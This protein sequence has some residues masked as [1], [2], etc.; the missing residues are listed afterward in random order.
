MA[1]DHVEV[2]GQDFERR[3]CEILA[4][5]YEAVEAGQVSDRAEWLARYPDLS[6]AAGRFLDDQD[7]L[8]ALTEP[9]RPTVEEAATSEVLSGHPAGMK[10]RSIGDYELIEEI[11]RGGMG[12]VF[13]ARQ[14]GLDRP[15]ALK[16]LRAD[17]LTNEADQERFLR[18]AKAAANLDHPNIVP[19]FEVGQHEGQNYFTMKLVGGTSLARRLPDYAS[20]QRAAARLVATVAL[21]VAHAHERGILH[22]DLKP[23]NILVDAH[24]QPHVSD[25]GLA[26]WVNEASDL[27]LSGAILGTPGYMAPEQATGKKGAVTTATDVYGLGAVLYTLLTGR[28]PFQADSVL[29][30]IEDVKGR[31]PDPPS[32]VNGCVDRDLETICLKCLEKE[33]ARRYRSA[34]DVADELERWLQGEPIVARPL[35][36]PARWRRWAWRR[37]LLLVAGAA[38]LVMLVLVGLGTQQA[39]RLRQAGELAQKQDRLIRGRADEARQAKYVSD[40]GRASVLI[41]QSEARE[42]RDV[43]DRYGTA[44]VAED[45]RGF[46]WY[47]LRGLTDVARKLGWARRRA[48]VPRRV[49]PRRP[50]VRHGGP[51]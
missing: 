26:R 49:C 43:L 18:E 12:V 41:A 21:A 34:Q 25:F 36:R 3:L 4:A 13:R 16:M 14:R 32:T 28:P 50:H 5:Y 15:V 33:P 31:E 19:I 23:S 27:T 10:G 6:D 20:D 11:A 29:E 24:G 39:I 1:S 7:R 45:L 9:L 47:Y 44:T 35:S 22:R 38:A 8:L 30:T 2:A 46:E 51:G 37:R 40:I 48:S 42:A 17:A